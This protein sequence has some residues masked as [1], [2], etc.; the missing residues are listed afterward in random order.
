MNVTQ[1][2]QEE[3]FLK[4]DKAQIVQLVMTQAQND[5]KQVLAHDRNRPDLKPLIQNLEEY[6]IVTCEENPN[7]N[8]LKIVFNFLQE[9][10]GS[11]AE[12]WGESRGGPVFANAFFSRIQEQLFSEFRD[13]LDSLATLYL[14]FLKKMLAQ[15]NPT[16]LGLLKEYNDY[17]PQTFLIAAISNRIQ[18]QIERDDSFFL[19][20]HNALKNDID[21][22]FNNNENYC[23]STRGALDQ[24]KFRAGKQGRYYNLV[25]AVI[26]KIQTYPHCWVS[27]RRATE[28]FSSIDNTFRDVLGNDTDSH[29]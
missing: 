21:I 10:R 7:E 18:F 12:L 4:I 28:L 22:L 17:L 13:N 16:V 9:I 29:V 15:K 8:P 24:V 25:H 1:D 27:F 14:S 26:Q 5:M 23:L 20:F 3:P 2:H 11:I 19:Q 6:L